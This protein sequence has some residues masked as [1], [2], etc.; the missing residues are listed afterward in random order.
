NSRAPPARCGIVAAEIRAGTRHRAR[1]KGACP[2]TGTTRQTWYYNR[3]AARRRPIG[4]AAQR[5]RNP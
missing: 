1:K 2:A 3:E 5:T 4:A